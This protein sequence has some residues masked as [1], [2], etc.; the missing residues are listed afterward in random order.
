MS[1]APFN[2][3]GQFYNGD[4]ASAPAFDIQVSYSGLS[5]HLML[6]FTGTTLEW[7]YLKTILSRRLNHPTEKCPVKENVFNSSFKSEFVFENNGGRQILS[8]SKNHHC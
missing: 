1:S 8:F 5:S 4:A 2:A 6:V 3:N 7:S